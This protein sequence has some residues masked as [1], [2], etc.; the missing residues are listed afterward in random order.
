MI[1]NQIASGGVGGGTTPAAP[2]EW[3]RPAD[4]PAL[5]ADLTD[6]AILE[7]LLALN[8]GVS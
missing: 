8:L 7:R 4:W 1:L 5:P 3:V 2:A 6:D